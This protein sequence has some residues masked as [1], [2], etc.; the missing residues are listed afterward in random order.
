MEIHSQSQ[1]LKNAVYSVVFLK[2]LF[3]EAATEEQSPLSA[4]SSASSLECT[5]WN[6]AATSAEASA[7]TI[8]KNEKNF[9]LVPIET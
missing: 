2:L 7:E 8:A 4:A 6:R 3:F 9:E 5:A 1:L